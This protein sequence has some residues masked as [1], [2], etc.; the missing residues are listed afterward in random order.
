MH[1]QHCHDDDDVH[2]PQRVEKR[3][4]SETSKSRVT[5]RHVQVL[6]SDDSSSDSED[7][8]DDFYIDISGT[9]SSPHLPKKASAIKMEQVVSEDTSIVDDEQKD[10]SSGEKDDVDK[11]ESSAGSVH[12]DSVTGVK[13]EDD[14]QE[15]ATTTSESIDSATKSEADNSNQK[16]EE[17]HA[18]KENDELG[19]TTAPT[20]SITSD[21]KTD[22]CDSSAEDETNEE[23]ADVIPHIDDGE[24]ADG[25]SS[26]VES[27]LPVKEEIDED[28]GKN[29]L[30]WNTS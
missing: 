30:S 24:K 12:S 14:A 25:D 22:C 27:E 9:R 1:D 18:S 17:K 11:S 23:D 28:N 2:V 5:S 10:A 19:K 4:N 26:D 29:K 16:N 20:E 3:N 15:S 6:N 13:G 21:S 8:E 7:S